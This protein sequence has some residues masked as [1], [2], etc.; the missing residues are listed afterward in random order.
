MSQVSSARDSA[1]APS[2]FGGDPIR[3]SAVQLGGS[4]AGKLSSRL[5]SIRSS[6][7]AALFESSFVAWLRR[8]DR[9][10]RFR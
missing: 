5:S 1:A 9:A 6:G 3:I 2:Y 10:C 4:L 8:R 7:G